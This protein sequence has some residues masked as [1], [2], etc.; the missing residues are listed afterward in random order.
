MQVEEPAEHVVCGWLRSVR[1]QKK[2][3]FAQLDDGS[4]AA[5]LQLVLRES[6]TVDFG[7]LRTSLGTGASVRVTGPLQRSPGT[8]QDWELVA[9]SVELVGGSDG[10]YP[11]QKKWHSQEFLRSVPHLRPRTR[12]AGAVARVRSAMFLSTHAFFANRGFLNVHTPLLTGCDAE[13]RH[14]YI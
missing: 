9:E 1:F 11:L 8:G 13:V 10:S 12:G 4:C 2:R 14:T 7:A 6:T 3:A 5:G